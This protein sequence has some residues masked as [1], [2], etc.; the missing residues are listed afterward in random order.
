MPVK[1]NVLTH[2]THQIEHIE[3]ILKHNFI[4]QLC[5]EDYRFLL[6]KD[7]KMYIPMVCFCDIPL[8][9]IKEHV[10]DYGSYCLGLSKE[11][12]IKNGL[13][14]VIY[15]EEKSAISDSFGTV[16]RNIS[17]K[18]NSDILEN[19]WKIFCLL[20]PYNGLMKDKKEKIFYEENEWR[21]IPKKLHVEKNNDIIGFT[22]P[23]EEFT[24]KKKEKIEEYLKAFRLE[25][26][27]CD[28][29]YIFVAKEDERKDIVTMIR[30]IK[31]SRYT[32]DEIDILSSKIISYDQFEKDI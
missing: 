6:K 23:F 19:M 29:K 12:G 16:L 18:G 26:E 21:Y 22:I 15:L 11:W 7:F 2:F 24:L 20:K 31:S 8:H 9:L 27:P 32:M 4:P 3:N 28:I 10:L 1:S 25:F 17:E 5:L 30:K 14:P 13:N